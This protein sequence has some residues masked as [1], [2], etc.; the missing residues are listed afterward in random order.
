MG[1][2]PQALDRLTAAVNSVS[3]IPM[4]MHKKSMKT[5][6]NCEK[7][8]NATPFSHARMIHCLHSNSLWG[9][10][11]DSFIATYNF[12]DFFITSSPYWLA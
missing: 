5:N 3:R 4:K 7:V 10:Y 2:A 12:H 11:K 1:A 9:R 8:M 6:K